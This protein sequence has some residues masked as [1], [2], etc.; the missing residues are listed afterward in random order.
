MKT[1][2]PALTPTLSLYLDVL[3]FM[4]ALSVLL[5]H[6]W[7]LVFPTFP[8]PWPGHAAVVVFFVISGFVIAHATAHPQCDFQ[9]YTGSRVARILSVSVPAI[10]LGVLISPWAGLAPIP[11]SGPMAMGASELIWRTLVNLLFIGQSWGMD[12]TPPYNPP[13]WSLCF[14]VWYYAIF[15]AWTY[16]PRQ[17][18]VLLTLLLCVM[19]GPK[20]LLLMPV[21][22]LGIAIYRWR[23][24]MGQPAALVL[25]AASLTAGA[26]F[27][28]LD[29]AV[30]IRSQMYLYCPVA[31]EMM[32]GANL[33]VGDFLLGLIVAANFVAVANIST[34]FRRM[35][36]LAQP[37]RYCAS[38]TFSTYLYHMPLAVLLWNGLA[39]RSAVGFYG[40]LLL[41]IFVLAQC[42]ERRVMFLRAA[43]SS[44]VRG[45]ASQ[46]GPTATVTPSTTLAK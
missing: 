34:A 26:A 40:L 27:Y 15:A 24:A 17:I 16:A 8:L 20:I 41:S 19:A 42:T 30:A 38:F 23:P 31:M 37:I 36:R 39:V 29:V 14:E 43:L 22:L 44:G 9:S 5:H 12:V 35:E 10:L 25:F 28:W 18:R 46:S 45:A 7:E 3:R 33:F 11:N 21:W 13:F 6:T 2:R 32:R 1:I 4:A